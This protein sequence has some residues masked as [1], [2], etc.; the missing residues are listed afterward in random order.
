MALR[1]ISLVELSLLCLQAFGAPR[2]DQPVNLRSFKVNLS[3]GVPRM[4][5]LIRDTHLP[6]EPQYPGV[7]SS[8]GIDLNVM[9][10][11]REE[12]LNEFDWEKEQAYL[13]RL[14]NHLQ[15]TQSNL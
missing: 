8:R 12:W 3:H 4:M 7:G 2:P 6:D 5:E 13:N 11:L 9:K 10:S 1:L 15:E 14:V